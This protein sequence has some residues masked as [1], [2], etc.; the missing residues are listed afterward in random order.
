M[1]LQDTS[2]FTPTCD[3]ESYL[4]IVSRCA[5][6]SWCV[7]WSWLHKKSSWHEFG[8]QFIARRLPKINSSTKNN[9]IPGMIFSPKSVIT[10]WRYFTRMRLKS[11]IALPLI[12][13]IILSFSSP[14]WYYIIA[15][16]W[17][18]SKTDCIPINCPLK[19][20]NNFFYRVE[21]IYLYL[22]LYWT[23]RNVENIFLHLKLCYRR[24][25]YW[26]HLSH[27]IN[28]YAMPPFQFNVGYL[29]IPMSN[30]MRINIVKC[31][32]SF[33]SS[34]FHSSKSQSKSSALNDDW[35]WFP[36]IWIVVKWNS[37]CKTVQIFHFIS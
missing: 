12:I 19:I 20:G 7:P 33:S 15:S 10:T 8:M 29:H 3:T 35:C 6:W 36:A 23:E 21:C 13:R 24:F 30:K 32:W 2:V 22:Y 28:S 27:I 31:M 4:S 9:V 37:F 11:D 25:P 34:I 17:G 14:D 18:C 16:F 1:T 26:C 5:A